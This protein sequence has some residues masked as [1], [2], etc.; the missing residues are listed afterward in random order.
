MTDYK[1]IFKMDLNKLEKNALKTPNLNLKVP[2][3]KKFNPESKISIMKFSNKLQNILKHLNN[4]MNNSDTK[5]L[6][7][8]A[9]FR[10]KTL[11]T[12]LN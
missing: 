10:S 5:Y 2:L 7:S 4:L 3:K 1:R 9:I 11:E 12:T 6:N 8:K